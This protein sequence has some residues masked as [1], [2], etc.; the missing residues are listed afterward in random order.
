MTKRIH[1]TKPQIKIGDV[2]KTNCY[3]DVEVIEYLG[4]NKIKVRFEVDGYERYSTSGNLQKGKVKN[5]N[6]PTITHA[7]RLTKT[8]SMGEIY[9]NTNGLPFKIVEYTD[10]SN[11]K[12]E[13]ESGYVTTCTLQRVREGSISDNLSPSRFQG[14]L[15]T[16]QGIEVKNVAK[17]KEYAHWTSMLARCFCKEYR[18]KYPTYEGT[19]V[20][21][22][23]LNF[24]VFAKWCREQPEFLLGHKVFLDKDIL[25]K[26]NKLYSPET[27][28]FVPH[29]VN[30]LFTKADASRGE[31]PIGV[32]YC[33]TRNVITACVRID[34]RT[35]YLGRFENATD[36][37]YVYKKAKESYIKEIADK[38]KSV[39][40]KECYLAMYKYEVDIT[41]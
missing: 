14:Y 26:G 16:L 10:A 24:T 21:D 23:W 32:S 37:F 19:I 22:E 33:T 5:P 25:N 40:S 31:Y 27:C 20:C 4:A 11:V 34:K 38:F 13:F 12:V 39:I 1:T 17:T 36:A 8:V 41:D 7:K 3:G 29:D 30:T 6:I 15:G 18:S 2:F 28:T 9:K 35:K